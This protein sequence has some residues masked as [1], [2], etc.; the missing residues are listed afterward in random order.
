MLQISYILDTFT[1]FGSKIGG[2]Q[3]EF[4]TDF[5]FFLSN[6]GFISGF[7]FIWEYNMYVTLEI[8]YVVAIYIGKM[9][10]LH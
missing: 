8:S 9:F 1:S 3:C 4:Y 5:E 6:K 10:E 7:C 2:K